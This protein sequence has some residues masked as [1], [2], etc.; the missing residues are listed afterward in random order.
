MEYHSAM[1]RDVLLIYE[2]TLVNL[3][4]MLGEIN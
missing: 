4:L 1:K 2:T 3:K